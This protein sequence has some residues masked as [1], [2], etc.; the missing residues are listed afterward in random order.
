MKTIRTLLCLFSL[1]ALPALITGCD[2]TSTQ[3]DIQLPRELTAEEQNVVSADNAFGLSLLSA[4]DEADPET[5]QF[6][7]P[8]SV[9]MA[10]GMTLNGATGDTR[11]QMAQVLNKQGLSDEVINMSYQSLATLLSNLDREVILNISN[12]IWYREGF[13]VEQDFLHANTTYFDAEVTALDFTDP[14]AVDPIN[15]WVDERTEGLIPKIIDRISAEA[16]MYLINAVYFKGAWTYEFD[17]EF[18]TEAPFFN[19]DGSTSTVPLMATSG[20]FAYYRAEDAS[21][22][23]IPY[24]DS[25]YSMTVVL[26]DDPQDLNEMVQSLS[27]E[28][29]DAYIE[30]LE[31][32][33][34]DLLLPRFTLEYDTSLRSTL[35][36]LGMEVPFSPLAA[37]FSRINPNQDLYISDV[38][39]K[40]FVEVNEEGTEAAAVTAVIV[41]TTS[42]GDP[43]P[44]VR[45]DKPFL[46]SI[47]ERTTGAL[48]FIG[49]I[50]QL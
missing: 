13:S 20:A 37:D 36:A 40:T 48:L 22:V 25:L 24:G 29:W 31:A 19:L 46:F 2:A 14:D 43:N 44:V 21:V 39:H 30:H 12:S 11:D 47:R 1:V 27:T 28:T 4:L 10:L 17:P 42:I 38:I 32:V 8:L 41:E 15:N 16:I 3:E 34:I 9:S 33:E 5:S 35:M 45:V 6:I 49:K 7:S 50:T 26:P 18:T 23:D